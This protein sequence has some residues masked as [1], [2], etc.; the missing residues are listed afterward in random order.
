MNYFLIF[1]KF[2]HLF[3][4]F[5]FNFTFFAA[6]RARQFYKMRE[7]TLCDICEGSDCSDTCEIRASKQRSYDSLFDDEEFAKVMET[8]NSQSI[9]V[10]NIIL[11]VCLFF[12]I[13]TR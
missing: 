12:T 5:I 1:I 9:Y 3:S 2:K 10:S 11:V 7:T 6:R 8:S 13:L 4:F